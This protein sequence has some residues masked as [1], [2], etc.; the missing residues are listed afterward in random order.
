MN[1]ATA[2]R[3]IPQGCF[4]TIIRRSQKKD[5][6]NKKSIHGEVK[7]IQVSY[8]RKKSIRKYMYDNYIYIGISYKNENNIL[9]YLDNKS[10]N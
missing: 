10:T 4:T 6:N 1:L 9:T 3:H 7:K 2:F 5:A 8:K